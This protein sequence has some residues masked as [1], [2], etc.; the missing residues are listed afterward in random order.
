MACTIEIQ[1]V[2]LPNLTGQDLI[3]EFSSNLKK[4]T[5]ADLFNVLDFE[6]SPIV[7]IIVR[8]AIRAK[9]QNKPFVLT[10]ERAI[11]RLNQIENTKR[12]NIIRR[13]YKKWGLFAIHEINKLYPGYNAEMLP[14]DVLI[15]NSKRKPGKKKTGDDFRTR[16]LAK[17][18]I[19]YYI[20]NK[21]STAFNKICERIAS[22]TAALKLRRPIVLTVKL[23]GEVYAYPFHWLTS[24]RI[25]KDFHALANKKGSTHAMLQEYRAVSIDRT[26]KF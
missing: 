5:W 23:Q 6:L 7:K 2:Q 16:Q 20:T 18:E 14:A 4:Y 17:L 12:K 22:L 11:S 21:N 26:V 10:L 13:L 1:P 3:E 25:I 19:Q 9:E 15:K 24:E 8:A